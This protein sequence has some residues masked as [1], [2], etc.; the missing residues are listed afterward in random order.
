M[1]WPTRHLYLCECSRRSCRQRFELD[2]DLY[3]RIRTAGLKLVADGHQS[4]WARTVKRGDGWRAVLRGR[5]FDSQDTRVRAART[6]LQPRGR[7]VTKR[8]AA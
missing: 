8:V 3:D 6:R 2:S 7:R 1:P 5:A 4:V